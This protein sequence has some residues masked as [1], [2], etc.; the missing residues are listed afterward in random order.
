MNIKI[1][2]RGGE[3]KI[4]FLHEGAFAMAGERKSDWNDCIEGSC[5]NKIVLHK[6]T[7]KGTRSSSTSKLLLFL[8]N[9][10]G[11][12]SP[13]AAG[14]C[15]APRQYGS[16]AG[17][18]A[19]VDVGEGA[20]TDGDWEG[21]SCERLVG[22]RNQLGVRARNANLKLTCSCPRWFTR[23]CCEGYRHIFCL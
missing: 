2:T 16:L 3:K 7:E 6:Q 13:A 9:G 8:P 19:E 22:N 12:T 18:W 20:P 1:K 21:T 15:P 14:A 10:R 4:F 11:S 17:D 23:I 5:C